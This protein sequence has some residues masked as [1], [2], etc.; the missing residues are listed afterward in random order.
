MLKSQLDDV[1]QA[2]AFAQAHTPAAMADDHTVYKGPE[3]RTTQWED[4][5][6]K[7]G[8]LPPK[9]PP[10]KP[11]PWTPD[12]GDARDADWLDSRDEKELEDLEDE[13]EDDRFLEQYRQVAAGAS[14]PAAAGEEAS[15]CSVLALAKHTE[16]AE[17][18]STLLP[19]FMPT[20][21]ASCALVQA[22][23]NAAA[24]DRKAE[25]EVRRSHPHHQPRLCAAGHKRRG[26][27]V[28]GRPPLQRRVTQDVQ[29]CPCHLMLGGVQQ[30]MLP[31][32]RQ[33]VAVGRPGDGAAC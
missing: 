1:A 27:G 23:A 16:S 28:G 18:P 29:P 25:A 11:D 30:A 31:S 12:K 24:E 6:R 19:P 21:T 5:Q 9:E 3:G 22:A 8:N 20:G 2:F 10:S 4:I 32:H 33:L 7:M 14:C 17:L 15:I 26:G 13:F